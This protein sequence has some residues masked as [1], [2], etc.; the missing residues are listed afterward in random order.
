MRTRHLHTALWLGA[1]AL[2][3]A[4]A[5]AGFVSGS[6][7]ADGALNVASNTTL[8]VQADGVHNYTTITIAPGA[9]LTFT[10]TPRTRRW[11]CSPQWT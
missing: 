1:A 7:G 5:T 3:A 9:T 11:C 6:T 8:P 10:T 4:P 2:L